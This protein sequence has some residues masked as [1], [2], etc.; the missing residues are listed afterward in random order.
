MKAL[1]FLLALQPSSESGEGGHWRAISDLPLRLQRA[2]LQVLP[3]ISLGWKVDLE[4]DAGAGSFRV[5]ELTDGGVIF[6]GGLGID[7]GA[8]DL[9][10]SFQASRSLRGDGVQTAPG[11]ADADFRG[12]LSVSRLTL[13]LRTIG[14]EWGSAP[15]PPTFD[16]WLR[17]IVEFAY[18]EVALKRADSSLGTESFKEEWDATAWGA[19]LTVAARLR[20]GTT[21][22]GLEAGW[23]FA[24]GRL[25]GSL[26]IES[27]R[28]FW[29][30]LTLSMIPNVD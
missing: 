4:F 8:L 10:V 26:D 12:R 7:F 20:S 29:M 16:V 25:G 24:G 22:F 18:A 23:L 6:G 21:W 2:S 1:A 14:V 17:P 3:M 11:V 5:D 13:G 28:E 27:R 15:A 30:G 9:S 19:G